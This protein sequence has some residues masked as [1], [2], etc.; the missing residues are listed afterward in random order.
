MET[1][2]EPGSALASA[3]D[4]SPNKWLLEA[5]KIAHVS[6]AELGWVLGIT[7]PTLGARLKKPVMCSDYY[8]KALLAFM[9]WRRENVRCCIGGRQPA[10]LPDRAPSH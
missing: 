2:T 3:S 7:G 6:L 1:H 10:P 5:M 9:D 8:W 4:E